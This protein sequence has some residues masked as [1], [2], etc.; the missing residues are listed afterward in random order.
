MKE[1]SSFS[2]GLCR[3]VHFLHKLFYSEKIFYL[4]PISFGKYQHSNTFSYRSGF[5][6]EFSITDSFI[7][8]NKFHYRAKQSQKPLRFLTMITPFS[9]TAGF[10][11]FFFPANVRRSACPLQATVELKQGFEA[12]DFTAL[13]NGDSSQ[14]I[15]KQ[16]R[17]LNSLKLSLSNS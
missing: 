15:L 17:A 9:A 16:W 10:L 6:S 2:S 1:E 7:A 12:A 3:N 8:K 5:S 4:I 13:N 11:S 14:P